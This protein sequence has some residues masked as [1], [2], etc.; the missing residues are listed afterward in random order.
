[1][2]KTSLTLEKK[3]EILVMS[4]GEKLSPTR[5]SENTGIART[6]II[7]FLNSYEKT[8][9]LS[10]KRGRK[11]KVTD[12]I[13]QQVIDA[14]ISNP[15]AHL[16]D[17]EANINLGRET[18]RKI[19]HEESF[20]YYELTP[21]SPLTEQHINNRISYC[22]SVLQNGLQPVIFTDESTVVLDLSKKGIW[23]KRGFHPPSSFFTQDHHPIQ[24]MVWGAIGPKGFRTNL[25]KCPDSLTAYNYCK[26]LADNHVFFQCSRLGHYIWQQDGA[27]SHR[28]VADLIKNHVPDMIIW[29]A[30]S[31]DLSPI[32]QV[33]AY[34][35]QKLRGISFN[36]ADELFERLQI[37]WQ[38]IP[39]SMIHN[40]W[41]SYYARA[42]V[43]N[44]LNGQSLNTH[45]KEVHQF[46]NTYR[47][48]IND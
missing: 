25:I 1:M 36:T 24:V 17:H 21:I 6:T 11:P 42:K 41:E 32:E 30:Y 44:D 8:H 29:P 22:R 23:R 33:W 35:K 28:A 46:H 19:L 39:N 43:C 12:E 45:W 26:L 10:P 37:E 20:N 14:T 13:K 3:A 27:P 15:F 18:I 2:A 31:P 16:K 9:E 5:I 7:S 38:N 40:F 4:K 48:P 47:Q 34:L